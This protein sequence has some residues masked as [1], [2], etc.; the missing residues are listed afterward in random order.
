MVH[1]LI[2]RCRQKGLDIV[3]LSWLL[4]DNWPMRNL[5][6]SLG[7]EHTKTYR[8]YEKRLG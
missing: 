5:A 7:G 8:L 1:M 2:A 4:E 6:E 3:E